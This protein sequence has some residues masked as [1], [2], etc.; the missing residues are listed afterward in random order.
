MTGPAHRVRRYRAAT[1]R[2]FGT[3]HAGSHRT[4]AQ[5]RCTRPPGETLDLQNRRARPF[6]PASLCAREIA[7]RH[8]VADGRLTRKMRHA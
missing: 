3:P 6:S 4:R 7:G 1:R 8:V 5:A 2:A